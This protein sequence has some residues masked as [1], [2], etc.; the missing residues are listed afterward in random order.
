MKHPYKGGF[1]LSATCLPVRTGCE[2]IG[3]VSGR[4]HGQFD[5]WAYA[6]REETAK[7]LSVVMAHVKNA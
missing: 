1:L 2:R 6:T 4:A 3:V 5:P 7:I